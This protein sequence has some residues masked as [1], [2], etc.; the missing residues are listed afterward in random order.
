VYKS[1]GWMEGYLNS[2]RVRVVVEGREAQEKK[3]VFFIYRLFSRE[4]DTKRGEVLQ[5]AEHFIF[6]KK[7]THTHHN[8][9]QENEQ[10]EKKTKSFSF[11]SLFKKKE[12]CREKM[13]KRKLGGFFTML[14]KT[15][16]EFIGLAI[17][18]RDRLIMVSLLVHVRGCHALGVSQTCVIRGLLLGLRT[19]AN[20]LD[21]LMCFFAFAKI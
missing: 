12:N 3:L 19:S 5:Y 15:K 9:A 2:G 21:L 16:I 14:S 10:F 1:G 17:N 8:T 7:N 6:E 13:T 4:I 18:H 11:R 20:L